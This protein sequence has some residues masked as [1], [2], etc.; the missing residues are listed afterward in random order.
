MYLMIVI[1]AVFLKLQMSLLLFNQCFVNWS[2]RA[3]WFNWLHWRLAL[4]VENRVES[5]VELA[6]PR[7][8]YISVSYVKNPCE[9]HSSRHVH[10]PI[11]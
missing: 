9:N 6:L 10:L 1:T 7:E 8:A 3:G 4:I 5:R 2:G 11:L